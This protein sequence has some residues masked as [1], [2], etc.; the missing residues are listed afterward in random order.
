MDGP[1]H[2]R[3]LATPVS[4]PDAGEVAQAGV[5]ELQL[6][7]ERPRRR[8]GPVVPRSPRVCRPAA[9]A[10]EIPGQERLEYLRVLMVE[11]EFGHLLVLCEVAAP[12]AQGPRQYAGGESDVQA[13]RPRLCGW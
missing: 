5:R 10:L 6:Q 9:V 1:S 4:N 3:G 12:L 13:G 7:D 8:G 2:D 11:D